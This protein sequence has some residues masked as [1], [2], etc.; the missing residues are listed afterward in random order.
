[1]ARTLQTL[2]IDLT[3][4]TANF[5]D[6]MTKAQ[7]ISLSSTA[8]I[9]KSFGLVSAAAVAMA[10]AVTGAIAGLVVKA[11]EYV[12]SIQRM[13]EKTGQTTEE[14]SK[15]AYASALTGG[16]LDDLGGV[17]T[18]FNRA[19]AESA[20]GNKKTEAAFKDLGVSV[21]DSSGRFKPAG[22]LLEQ[23][24]ASLGR[25]PD[26]VQKTAL[27]M[28][29]FGR[30][31]AQLAPMLKLL[32]T[33]AAQTDADMKAF[34]LTVSGPQAAAAEKLAQSYERGKMA[35]VGFG[36]SV[37]AKATP[38]LQALLD[39]V[40]A[41]ASNG[42]LL[43]FAK[44]LG[45][46]ITSAATAATKA[47]TFL[48]DHASTV[49]T[50]IKGIATAQVLSFLIGINTNAL[51]ATSGVAKLATGFGLFLG[52]A[53]GLGNLVKGVYALGASLVTTAG[54]MLFFASTEGVA[55]TATTYLTAAWEKFTAALIA[56]PGT[57]ALTALAAGFA[58]LYT[59]MES[60]VHQAERL[61]GV[62]ITWSDQWT[63][64]IENTKDRLKAL[65]KVIGDLANGTAGIGFLK[66]DVDA[67][68]N[69]ATFGHKAEQIAKQRVKD[70][71]A[72]APKTT[73]PPTTTL[74]L[75]KP[76]AQ[77]AKP[78]PYKEELAKLNTELRNSQLSLNAAMQESVDAQR[79][80]TEAGKAGLII[81]ELQSKLKRDLTKAEREA[82]TSRVVDTGENTH[83]AQVVESLHERLNATKDAVAADV[84]LTRVIGL[85]AS[86]ED[87]AKRAVEQSTLARVLGAS[88]TAKYSDLLKQL[89]QVQAQA[90]AAARSRKAAE[91]A[92]NLNQQAADTRA[93]ATATLQGAGA[94]EQETLQ[95]RLNAIAREH[96]GDPAAIN[97]LTA[98]TQKLY[99]SERQ[100]HAIEA[101]QAYTSPLEQY[102][103]A[104]EDITRS[105][106]EA[107]AAGVKV[108]QTSV[109]MAN[110]EA[111]LRYQDALEKIHD[112]TGSMSDGVKDFFTDM[113]NHA[114]SAATQVKEIL[115]Q[116]FSGL[117]DNLAKLMTGQKT[118]WASMFRS[119]GESMV[120]MGL[121]KI[122][123]G[124]ASKLGGG[125][126]ADGSSGNPFFVKLAGGLPG[127]ASGANAMTQ[128]AQSLMGGLTQS[129]GFGSMFSSLLSG[130]MSFIPGGGFLSSMFG[131]HRALGGSVQAGMSYDVGEAG[132][133]TFVPGVSGTIIPNNRLGGGSGVSYT[134]NNGNG[135]T[136]EQMHAYTQSALSQYHTNV[137]RSSSVSSNRDYSQRRPTSAR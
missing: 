86:A 78:D 74:P 90:D 135:V 46:D 101:G 108:D 20:Q 80:A 4:N 129:S 132:R 3:A 67:F 92:N 104:V 130:A 110:R 123:S 55:L 83:N 33:N 24:I 117:N 79:A 53:T 16:N 12:T 56:N 103:K 60:D 64:A 32:S 77:K 118:Q 102:R 8:N 100:L 57:V 95:L 125:S 10:T 59:A 25:M 49:G 85:G 116:A 52:K 58:I 97:A 63:A 81:T 75:P 114:Q 82:I 14:I 127:M 71:A 112:V 128:G 35:L 17:L 47:L 51:T 69:I 98:A 94:V 18:K 5:S 106:N 1:M 136:P 91:D 73:A 76:T 39:K 68:N 22:Q 45:E 41:L 66:A 126:K 120:K 13:A 42:S 115:G 37:L 21:T 121:S 54:E 119:I 134:I 137:A 109:W 11:D 50:V 111:A 96:A 19:A 2:T 15:L 29:V 36:E 43:A 131:G 30:S 27:E 38:A 48:S 72:N 40:L 65:G 34:G 62:A 23:T 124:I 84:A 105:V 113:V 31:G 9:A 99:E 28:D 93:L 89:A 61:G 70:A 88:A 44:V 133:E 26:S 107:A 7:Q 122:E 87:A 6:A